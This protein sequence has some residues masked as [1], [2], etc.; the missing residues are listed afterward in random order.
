MRP[1]RAEVSHR[2]GGT[3]ATNCGKAVPVDQRDGESRELE[4]AWRGPRWWQRLHRL[5]PDQYGKRRAREVVFGGLIAIGLGLALLASDKIVVLA[6]LIT[7]FGATPGKHSGWALWGTSGDHDRLVVP[8]DF[9]HEP[10]DL[11]E[12]RLH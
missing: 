10:S 12:L 8:S 7:A 5:E 1:N 6:A 2:V 9:W 11:R 4:D 3:G